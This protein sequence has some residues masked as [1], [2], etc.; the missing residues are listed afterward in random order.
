MFLIEQKMRVLK[1]MS[2]V[3]SKVE[4]TEFALKVGLTPAQTMEQVQ[5]LAKVGF[6]S[7]TPTGYGITEKGKNALKATVQL[8]DEKHFAFYICLNEPTGFSAASLIE[9]H[10]AVKKVDLASLEF[11]LFRGDFENWVQTSVTDATFAS[12][13]AIFKQEGLKG[14]SL[15]KA[16]VAALESRYSLQS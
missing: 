16:L 4:L 10:D 5:A 15:R 8:P 3:K 13:L 9:F 11:H 2:E 7:K 14:E 6:V 12:E 1:F